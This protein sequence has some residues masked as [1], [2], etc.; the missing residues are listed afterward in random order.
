[1]TIGQLTG[2]LGSG[3]NTPNG[4]SVLGNGEQ[5]EHTPNLVSIGDADT[6][7]SADLIWHDGS[8]SSTGSDGTNLLFETV[9]TLPPTPVKLCSAWNANYIDSMLG[10]DVLGMTSAQSVPAAFAN[11][12]LV[13]GSTAVFHG[14]FDKTGCADVTDVVLS[15]D[16]T[17]ATPNTWTLQLDGTFTKNLHSGAGKAQFQV[18]PA[19]ALPL[20]GVTPPTE[21]V[22]TTF[23]VTGPGTIQANPTTLDEVTGVSAFVSVVLAREETDD[24]GLT[25][26]SYIL[27]AKLGCQGSDCDINNS[28]CPMGSQCDFSIGHCFTSC[29]T[30][31]DCSL[32]GEHCDPS[33]NRCASD[34][35]C[36][37]AQLHQLYIAPPITAANNCP[38]NI[39]AGDSRWKFIIAHEFGHVVQNAAGAALTGLYNPQVP[40][41]PPVCRCD[42]VTVANQEHCMQGLQ[43][44][45]DSQ[46]EG[47]AHFYSANVW[48]SKVLSNGSQNASCT[49]EYYKEFLVTNQPNL[50][51]GD[52]INIQT[53]G[54]NPAPALESPCD[55]LDSGI[56]LGNGGPG[57]FF[58][59]KPPMFVD[60]LGNPTPPDPRS[61]VNYRLQAACWPA[62]PDTTDLTTEFDWLKFYTNINRNP[63]NT[64]VTI[65][66]TQILSLYNTLC[67][68]KPPPNNCNEGTQLAPTAGTPNWD[69]LLMQAQ[70]TLSSAR[71]ALFAAAGKT[72]G[73]NRN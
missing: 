72:F 40:N 25:A 47:F 59:I 19:Q 49:F 23:S 24:L 31:A 16:G 34:N 50:P 38:A 1:M 73:V 39:N 12:A 10:E 20:V 3:T 27:F 18:T 71:A 61:F 22:S 60:C 5:S 70:T 63:M 30:D 46:E 55:T 56:V 43:R 37:D 42:H 68:G 11:F 33:S 62:S 6:G 52:F 48:N 29:T 65:P 54:E 2:D 7:F 57:T 15:P 45:S 36:A 17:I 21:T 32:L 66:I 14:T 53:P 64:S 4:V 13:Q 9:A 51:S 28:N 67:G 58:S 35:S 44:W 69:T 41:R 8:T 26:T